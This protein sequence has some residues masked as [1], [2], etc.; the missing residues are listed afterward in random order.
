MKFFTL[1]SSCLFLSWVYLYDVRDTPE[2]SHQLFDLYSRHHSQLPRSVAPNISSLTLGILVEA[3]SRFSPLISSPGYSHLM[4]EDILYAYER[5]LY[6]LPLLISEHSR[7]HRFELTNLDIAASNLPLEHDID[8]LSPK[9]NGNLNC[10]LYGNSYG[11]YPYNKSKIFIETKVS[12][13]KL[14][15]FN[16]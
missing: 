2:P 15:G 6:S 16:L 12:A 13:M 7:Y 11:N 14:Q 10:L 4:M 5:G 1:I 8:I 3:V 9:P